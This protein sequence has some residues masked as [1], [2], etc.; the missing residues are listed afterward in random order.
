MDQSLVMTFWC[1]HERD[2]TTDSQEGSDNRARKR[3]GTGLGQYDSTSYSWLENIQ[4][5][6]IKTISR[7]RGQ[8]RWLDDSSTG[9]YARTCT[10]SNAGYLHI[11]WPKHGSRTTTGPR[12]SLQKCAWV[13]SRST[14]EAGEATWT[15]ARRTTGHLWVLR[16]A[17]RPWAT[18]AISRACGI[19]GHPL[20]G[21]WARALSGT[22]P[23]CMDL[24]SEHYWVHQILNSLK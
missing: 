8:N 14:H 4:G 15:C 21:K 6:T 12:Q 2:K 13:V 17:Y 11:S 20:Y 1:K 10:W 7:S 22:V 23:P 9:T 16:H 18:Q 24:C 19:I 3:P 5:P